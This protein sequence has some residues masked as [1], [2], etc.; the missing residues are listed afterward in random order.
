MY[1]TFTQISDPKDGWTSIRPFHAD[2][3][4]HLSTA[5]NCPFLWSTATCSD[6][7][8]KR[9]GDAFGVPREEMAVLVISCDTPNIYQQRR[10]TKKALSIG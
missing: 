9:I 2:V 7:M 10:I 6:A 4:L 1:D 3:W 8:L 5:H